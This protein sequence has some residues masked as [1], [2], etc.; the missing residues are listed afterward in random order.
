MLSYDS[1][2]AIGPLA[3]RSIRIRAWR[4]VVPPLLVLG[5]QIPA[6]M[7]VSGDSSWRKQATLAPIWRAHDR[8]SGND[9]SELGEGWGPAL[10]RVLGS[11]LLD[12][13]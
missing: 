7:G 9:L 2:G 5:G 11:L 1:T 6:S 13:R 8:S 4:D 10:C 3:A 12:H